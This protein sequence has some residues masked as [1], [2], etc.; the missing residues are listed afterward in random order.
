MWPWNASTAG[1]IYLLHFHQP[2]GNLANPR[3]QA[4]HYTGFAEDL[5]ARLLKQLTGRGAAIVAAAV[6]KGITFDIY[7][8]PATLEV[9]KLIKR[10]KET[11]V[12]CPTCARLAGRKPRP[13]PVPV[14][15]LALPLDEP[16][17]E[18]PA[19][20]MDWLEMTIQREWRQARV[21]PLVDL[22]ALDDLL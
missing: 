13:L 17:P 8:W 18:V 7:H 5:E 2:L 14:T 10:R 21:A 4:R 16:L 1:H 12:F 11:A 22:A 15:Q 9:E 6:A 3:A 19:G 20:R